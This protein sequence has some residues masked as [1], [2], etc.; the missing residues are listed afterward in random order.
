MVLRVVILSVIML[1]GFPDSLRA[2]E[3]R[4]QMRPQPL[5][6]AISASRDRDWQTAT[7][8]AARAGG[9]SKD[10]VEWLRLR[11]GA[12][13]VS[14]ALAFMDR[15]SDWPGLALLARESEAGLEDASEA[16]VLAFFDGRAPRSALGARRY[17]RVLVQQGRVAEAEK[18]LLAAWMTLPMS[19]DEQDRFLRYF[20]NT[21]N[22]KLWDR[23]DAMLWKGWQDNARQL[24]TQLTS[25]QRALLEARIGLQRRAKNVDTLIANVP[26]A[27]RNDPGLQ[28]DR[29]EWRVRKSR[30]KDAK[31]LLLE[32]SKS[33]KA[34]GV[35]SA[36][37]NRRRALA[38]DEMRDGSARRAYQLASKHFLTTG[39]HYADLEWLS[40]YIALTKLG[41]AETA[42]EHFRN[43]DAA[44]RSPISQGRAGYWQGR[45][46]RALGRVAEADQAFT[47]GAAHQSSFYGLLAAE[48]AGL[49][50]YVG[51]Q[52]V[53]TSSWQ[54]SVLEQDS[55]FQAG[56]LL[57]R[58]GERSLAEVF[59][60]H[61]AEQLGE[62]DAAL[63]GQAAIDLGEPHL[64]VMIGKAVARR[65]TIVPVPYYALHPL[66]ESDLPV[67]TELALAIARRESEFDPVVVSGAGARGLM[68][69][70]PATG[71]E[72]SARLGLSAGHSNARLTSDP[73]YNAR[74]GS[75]FLSELSDQF[76][77]NIVM[78]S[79]GYNA[80]PRRPLRWMELY[81]DPRGKDIDTM[82]DW[83]E[84]IPFRET[85]NYVMRV[86]ES[87]PIY[88]ARLGQDPHPVSFSEEL[89]AIR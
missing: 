45:A 14:Q 30:W 65:G 64:A 18:V 35:P 3:T 83:I 4:P 81:G 87:L 43:H 40:G 39:S 82:I 41:N 85:R 61:L 24:A 57:A 72:V 58:A 44:V 20:D 54:G 27:L 36:W 71:K 33:A 79:A 86:S 26:A 22:G 75:Q 48:A 9:V 67:A 55:L 62:H 52:D 80:G 60:T 1:G 21:L 47:A 38:R 59:W 51:L 77:G 53:P 7:S 70:M 6:L 63:L 29:F 84:G 13:S 68:Q 25:G 50:F 32:Q 34:L 28:H 46:L 78:L 56:L 73:V 12:G 8:L 49:P 19:K 37:S 76:R 74:L 5:A 17:A 89:T 42:L 31:D 2:Q 10:I 16:Q 15:R 88:R 69:L 23:A 66:A 11:A